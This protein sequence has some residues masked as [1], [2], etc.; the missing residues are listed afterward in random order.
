MPEDTQTGVESQAS[1][2]AGQVNQA[3]TGAQDERVEKAFAARLSKEREKIEQEFK[4]KYQ[5]KLAL[6]EKFEQLGYDP[7]EV[8]QYLDEWP[9]SKQPTQPAV[10]TAN[11]PVTP[12][13]ETLAQ[14][15]GITPQA[16]KALISLYTQVDTL[17]VEK[18]LTRLKSTYGDFDEAKLKE[19]KRDYE[20]KHG[21]KLTYEAAYQLMTWQERERA[22]QQKAI[23]DLRKNAEKAVNVGSGAPPS[24]GVKGD[25]W[26]MKKEDFDSILARVK[27]GE[28]IPIEQ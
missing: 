10:P 6:A 8:S 17:S 1:A 20:R 26:K 24:P 3:S 2:D 23:E 25:F 11:V 5:S 7:E 14:Q 4:Q 13:E 19:F 16:A 18:E 9:G 28:K 22:G 15:L 27:S 12:L 21:A